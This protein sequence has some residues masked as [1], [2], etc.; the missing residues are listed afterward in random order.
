MSVTTKY[1]AD[2][3]G[4]TRNNILTWWMPKVAIIAS[5]FARAPLRTVVWTVALIWTGAACILN[6]RRCGR[7]QRSYTGPY[8]LAIIL[9]VVLLASGVVAANLYGW[10]TLAVT[11]RLW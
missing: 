3:V 10:L 11:D 6:A 4:N 2:W 7:T 5:L 1:V 9:P 8:Y